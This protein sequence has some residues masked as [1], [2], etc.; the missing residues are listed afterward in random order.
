MLP[1][2]KLSTA[3]VGAEKRS[4]YAPQN[5]SFTQFGRSVQAVTGLDNGFPSRVT[6]RMPLVSER[7]ATERSGAGRVSVTRSEAVLPAAERRAAEC[8]G[9][10]RVPV[11][12]PEQCFFDRT[13]AD[14][15]D[16]RIGRYVR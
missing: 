11:L 9:A 1:G 12:A 15:D 5:G 8:S 16:P 2:A 7:R 10:G 6:E 4:F 3:K 13:R 14:S